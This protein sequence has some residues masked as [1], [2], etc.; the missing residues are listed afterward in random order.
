VCPETD[1]CP[2]TIVLTC[3][4]GRIRQ[5][6]LCGRSISRPSSHEDLQQLKCTT[7]CGVAKRNARLAE[8]LGISQENRTEIWKVNYSDELLNFARANLK[9]CIAVEKSFAEYVP[10]RHFYSG[11]L[12]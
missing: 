5:P 10:F 12:I 7:E 1:E 2:A 6:V 11:K 3:P 8:A 4:C 9:V